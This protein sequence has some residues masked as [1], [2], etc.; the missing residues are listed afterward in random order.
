LSWF[1]RKDVRAATWIRI[2]LG[3]LLLVNELVW[4]VVRYHTEGWRFPEGL[5]LQLCDFILWFTII[6]A[7]TLGQWSIDFAYF[8]TIAGSGMAI[9]TPDLWAP[10][11]SYP[12]VYFFLAHGLSIVTVLTLLWQKSAR[13]RAD[14]V[15]RAFGMLNLIAVMVGIFDWVFGTNYMYLRAK[16]AHVSLLN[17]LGP[18]PVYILTGEVVALVLFCLLAFPFRRGPRRDRHNPY[19]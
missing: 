11:P 18:W 17:Y 15:W 2:G 13:I 14:S 4:Y 6:A 10:F 5:P 7:L 3:V 8:G 1:G 12:T 19:L 9:L 16:P